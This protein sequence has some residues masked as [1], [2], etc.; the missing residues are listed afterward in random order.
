MR[1]V[2]I[3]PK[4]TS[5]CVALGGGSDVIGVSEDAAIFS[6]AFGWEDGGAASNVL[7]A[8]AR[9]PGETGGAVARVTGLRA[10]PGFSEILDFSFRLLLLSHVRL[11]PM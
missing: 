5:T 3:W 6:G 11:P 4:M 1:I 2:T 7:A 8:S 9:L 10:R